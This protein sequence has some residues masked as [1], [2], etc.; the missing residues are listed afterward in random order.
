MS[1]VVIARFDNSIEAHLAKVHLEAEGFLCFLRNEHLL[2]MQPL[3]QVMLGGVELVVPKE[4]ALAAK[5]SWLELKRRARQEE[6]LRCPN[7]GS[8]DILRD[9]K[10][11]GE[12]YKGFL[13][14]FFSF[15]LQIWPPHYE[16]KHLCQ[17]CK[18]SFQASKDEHDL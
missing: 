12:G 3:Y 7:C 5:R 1:F 8:A 10:S 4:Q 2:T 16:T 9:V 11:G 6:A 17:N 15:L 13:A 14:L 18:Q